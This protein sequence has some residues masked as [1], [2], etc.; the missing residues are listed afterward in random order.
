MRF[1]VT[2]TALS[3]TFSKPPPQ[4]CFFMGKYVPQR[5]TRLRFS[6]NTPYSE[7]LKFVEIIFEKIV[8]KLHISISIADVQF[9]GLAQ[10][11]YV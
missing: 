1:Y 4:T 3:H 10:W 7:G 9:K 5:S 11:G 2:I 8:G 6:Q